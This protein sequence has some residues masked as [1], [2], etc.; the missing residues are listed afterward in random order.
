MF[1]GL[2]GCVVVDVLGVLLV[3]FVVVVLDSPFGF[4][5]LVW[6]HV[7][8]CVRGVCVFVVCVLCSFVLLCCVF[9]CVFLWFLCLCG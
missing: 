8:V 5:C 9:I 1:N 2:C 6:C 7:F 3:V 4:V